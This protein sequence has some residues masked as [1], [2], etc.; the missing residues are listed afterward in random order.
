MYAI[1]VSFEDKWFR[2]GSLVLAMFYYDN[3]YQGMV[4][5]YFHTLFAV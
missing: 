5:N 3:K 1:Q 4:T 2:L